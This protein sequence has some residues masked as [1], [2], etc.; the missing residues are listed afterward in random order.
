MDREGGLH[1]KLLCLQDLTEGK[2]AP[3]P[4]LLQELLTLCLILPHF[5]LI[6]KVFGEFQWKA[7]K[8]I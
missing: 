7:S 3:H 1:H 4:P 6:L 8:N 5:A 2:Q